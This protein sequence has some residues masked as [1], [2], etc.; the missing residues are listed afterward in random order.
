M[1]HATRSSLR[2]RNRQQEQLSEFRCVIVSGFSQPL[3]AVEVEQ[4]EL[5]FESEVRSGG[6]PL[7]CPIEVNDDRLQLFITYQSADGELRRC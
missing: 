1:A 7:E 6:G 4:L 3:S 2:R 5:V